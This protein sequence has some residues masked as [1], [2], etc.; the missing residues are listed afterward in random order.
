[1]SG[2]LAASASQD[3]GSRCDVGSSSCAPLV[4]GGVRDCQKAGPTYVAR[5]RAARGPSRRSAHFALSFCR[6][7][8]YTP[9][10]YLHL[11]VY[12]GAPLELGVGEPLRQHG[13]VGDGE[14]DPERDAHLLGHSLVGE[15]RA[16]LVAGLMVALANVALRF[17]PAPLGGPAD[18]V[19]ARLDREG[20]HAG[21]GDRE[22][23]A[24]AEPPPP[25]GPPDPPHR[26]RPPPPP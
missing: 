23:V 26:F 20:G 15:A 7:A 13:C 9:C 16:I 4:A 25:S 14:R 6:T 22:V 24:P 11:R 5:G 17:V 18:E 12:C 3:S 1:M 21:L 2:A 8:C 10:K 19:H